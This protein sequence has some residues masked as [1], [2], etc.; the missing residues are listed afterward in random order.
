MAFFTANYLGVD[1]GLTL[2]KH[3][4]QWWGSLE[5]LQKREHLLIFKDRKTEIERSGNSG[6]E[7]KCSKFTRKFLHSK[8]HLKRNIC[9]L[10]R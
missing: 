5:F 6:N 1:E 2:N 10:D 4:N 9:F 8:D 7:I 3:R